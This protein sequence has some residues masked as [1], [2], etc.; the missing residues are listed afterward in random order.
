MKFA[1]GTLASL[2]GTTAPAGLVI[3]PG[4]VE[5]LELKGNTVSAR[6]SI[7]L[8]NKTPAHLTAAIQKA[9][10]TTGIKTKKFAVSILSPDVLLRFFVIP[11]VPR[12]EWD[13]AVQFEARKYIPF[14]TD[15]LVWDAHVMP[16]KTSGKLDVIF[17]AVKKDTF[18][19]IEGALNAADV[20]PTLIEPHSLSMARLTAP[21]AAKPAGDF[22]CVV[23]VEATAAHLSIVRNGVPYL[24]R[25]LSFSTA[26][27]QPDV[28]P[29]ETGADPRSQRLLSELSVSIDFF[30]RE[31]ASAGI[32]K[33][34]LFGDESLIAPWCGWLADQLRCPVELG[35]PLLAPCA[36]RALPLTFASAAGVLSA[37]K[38]RRAA[39]LDFLNRTRA[40]P[41]L[42]AAKTAKAI[43]DLS[44][45]LAS[46][47]TPQ[48][49]VLGSVLAGLLLC[50]WFIGGGGVD[51][52]RRQL[53]KLV[54][55]ASQVGW[56]LDGMKREELE[57]V[58]A[59]IKPPLALLNQ[60]MDRR[61]SV[62]AKLDALAR[63][64]PDG[65]WLTGVTYE[66]R[67]EGSAKQQM[68]RLLVKGACFLGEDGQELSAI[69]DMESRIKQD[70]R[71]FQGF[72]D[73]RLEEVAA[74]KDAQRSY[75]YRTFQLKCS[76]ERK[77]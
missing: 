71:F 53:Q 38:T 60:L 41:A 54:E 22:V 48:A 67:M 43:P 64:L 52:K 46:L 25:D 26:P 51:A 44:G 17:A 2:A 42:S 28:G 56:G 50:V 6:A 75:S 69:Q 19:S 49:F 66:D 55:S 36:D 62:A 7:P 47:K 33:I 74:Q 37:A 30:T 21:D 8:E 70:P 65:V 10:E 34:W 32:T 5:L 16:S 61:V 72:N 23:D 58:A 11:V 15:E 63:S 73:G 1:F 12:A 57:P 4:A 3:R 29:Q 14:K 24:A 9:C 68:M 18:A 45:V 76:S 40:K 13:G 31:Y 35:T 20:Q 27:H 59:K 39:S 77:L